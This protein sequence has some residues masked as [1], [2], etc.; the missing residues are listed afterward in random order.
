M[1]DGETVLYAS[2]NSLRATLNFDFDQEKAF[3]Y[4][5]LSSQQVVEHIAHFVADLW[6]IH[7]FGEGNARTTA[8]F[9]ILYLRKLGFKNV[10]NAQFAEHS[11]YFRN[12][13]V[14]ANYE[15]LSR[16]IHKT[17]KYL[18]RFFGNV[19]F[20]EK[21]I[22]KNRELHI[23]WAANTVSNDPANTTIDTVNDTV[24]E[25]IKADPNITAE[26]IRVKLGI[27][28]ATAKR[29]IKALKNAGRIER[30]GSDKTGHWMVK[31]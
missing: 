30:H 28:I 12:A 21:H 31:P 26:E 1:L 22:L 23:Q 5:G 29:R 8:V 3:N 15:D 18:V 27:G 25:L 14:R 10:D 7:I 4:K 17:D 20:G 6:Q 16:S 9:I 13:L 19:L 2:F 24:F 11:W